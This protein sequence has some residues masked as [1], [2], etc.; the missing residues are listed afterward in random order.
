MSGSGFRVRGLNQRRDVLGDAYHGLLQ[1]PWFPFIAVIVGGYVVAN[2]FFATI[3]T[4]LPDAI[5][6]SKGFADNFFFSVQTW[7][8]IGYGGMTP[9][10]TA[11]NVVVV[12]ESMS[13]IFGVAILTGLLF[14]KFSRPSSKILFANLAVVTTYN[15]KPTLMIRV[16]NERHNTIADATA[17]LTLLRR[18]VTPEGIQ[19]RRLFDLALSREMQPVFRMTWTLMHVIDE[20]SPLFELCDEA[21]L[22]AADARIIVSMTGYDAVVGQTAHASFVYNLEHIRFGHRYVDASR[23]DEDDVLVLDYAKFHLAEPQRVD[24][25]TAATLPAAP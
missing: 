19:M 5:A 3:Y 15:G 18:T 10:S 6:G 20:K 11:A 13:G 1:M 2:L 25:S 7:A 12:I 9:K 17:R 16:A 23:T 21:A 4:L 8:T 22:A 24:P 14:A